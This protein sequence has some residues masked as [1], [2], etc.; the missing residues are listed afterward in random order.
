MKF[1]EKKIGRENQNI[2]LYFLIGKK[3]EEK[4]LAENY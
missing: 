3:K 4:F 1:Q 2:F